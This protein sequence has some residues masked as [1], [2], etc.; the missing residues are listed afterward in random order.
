MSHGAGLPQKFPTSFLNL[1][2]KKEKIVFP[3]DTNQDA[4]VYR[5]RAN[6]REG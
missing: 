2:D 3:E 5:V 6:T 4:T 1:L